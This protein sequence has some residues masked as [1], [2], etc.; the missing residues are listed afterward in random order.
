L[1]CQ[2][3]VKLYDSVK[4]VIWQGDQYRLTDPG[5]DNVASVLYMDKGKSTGILFN[6]LV[7][8]RYAAGSTHPIQLKGLM[9]GKKY[10]LREVNLYPET[11]STIG[12]DKIY[13][14]E[15]LMKIGFN[16]NVR[17]GRNSVVVMVTEA[18]K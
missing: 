14:G 12:A 4:Q 2:N 7:N 5:Q 18:G 3:A 1:F 6:Y 9:P 13:T 11:K 17:A 10:Q 15:Y 8:N 16:P